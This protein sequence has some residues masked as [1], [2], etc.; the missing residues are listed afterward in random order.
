VRSQWDVI[1]AGAG[2]GGM[3]CAAVLARRGRRVLLLERENRMGGRLRSYE[4]DG[5]VV[6]AGAYL[7][8]NLHLDAALAAAGVNDFRGSEIPV[9]RVLRL[10]VQG[11]EGRCFSFPWPGRPES[12]DMLAAAEAALGADASAFGALTGLWET[13]AALPDAEVEA[14]KHVSVRD[15]LPRFTTEPRVAEAF[16]RN[17][18][19][20]GAYDPDSASMAECIALR[21]RRTDASRPRPECAGDNPGGGVRALPRAIH[22]ALIG[23]GV[24]LRLGHQ[25][26][27]IIIEGGRV[28]GV[29]A[30]GES[31]FQEH[32]DAPAVVS[33]LP[34]WQLFEIT[35]TAH[36]P[37]AFVENA[38]RFEIVGGTI[39]A[40]FAFD[41]LPHL[42]D[43][44]EEDTFPGWSRLLIGP[45]REFGGGLVWVTHHSPANAPPGKHV[46]QAMRLSPHGEIADA[47]RVRYIHDAFRAMLDEIYLDAGARLMWERRWVTRDGSEYMITAAARPPVRAPGVAGLYLVGE[48]TDVGAV[49]MDAAAAS[50][51]RAAELI[52][53]IE[54]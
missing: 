12:P 3:L 41:G 35:S 36:F 54:S 5:F 49:Q 32:F 39:G 13:L 37:A 47:G 45:E 1:V 18:M 7:W 42:R 46:L 44:G 48:T 34:I 27:Q 30:H 11:N 28:C 22:A 14:L 50:A 53:E 23:S 51:L 33:N 25:V 8:P 4:L 38:R 6:D 17:L 20:F 31:P 10:F 19:L 52:A 29:F 9:T 40:A 24:D 15:A 26:D 16:R 21:R 43:G 2:L